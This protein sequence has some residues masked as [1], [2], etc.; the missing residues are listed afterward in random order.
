MAK[1]KALIGRPKFHI[2]NIVASADLQLDLDLYSIA[3][4]VYDVEYEPEQFPG[5]IFKM[6]E[7]KS[8]LLLFKNGKII[9]TGCKSEKE[10]QK[11][12][13]KTQKLL[14][15]YAKNIRKKGKPKF[16]VENIVASANFA[17]M[18][19]LYGIASRVKD[20]EY[21]PEQFPGAIFKITEP[22]KS[23]LLLFKNGKIICTGCKSEKEVQQAL[24]KT[25]KLMQ[26]FAS[27]LE[28]KK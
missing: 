19:D 1:K 28:K 7:P 13:N 23:S 10:V 20:V 6:K 3:Y 26:Q 8:S 27:P 5:A 22:V 17:V 4:K 14:F 25:A 9:C 2:E 15:K 16:T 21:E 18:L 12:V 11:A 24:N